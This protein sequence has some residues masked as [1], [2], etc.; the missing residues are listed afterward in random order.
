MTVNLPPSSLI[1]FHAVAQKEMSA[2][3]WEAELKAARSAKH[4]P[5]QFVSNFTVNHQLQL[6]TYGNVLRVCVCK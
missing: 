3:K 6:S 1:N 5:L 4:F 2:D